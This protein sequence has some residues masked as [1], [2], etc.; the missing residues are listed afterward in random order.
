M[1]VD[2]TGVAVALA[3]IAGT[4]G[5]AALTQHAATRNRRLDAMIHRDARAEE[6][7]E[8]ARETANAEKRA[9]YV[10]LNAA[11]RD[12]RAAGHDL[13]VDKHPG[14]DLGDL[15]PL[16]IARTKYRDVYARA[17]MVLPRR[18]LDVATEVNRCLG[19][20]YRALLDLD[21]GLSR[22]ISVEDLHEWYDRTLSDAVGLLRQVLR[23]DLGVEEY[24]NSIGSELE[25]L[26]QARIKLWATKD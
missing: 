6:R 15:E 16:E 10:E 19:R 7:Q 8:A 12:F 24:S 5:A 25:R 14:A 22:S 1:S 3:G 11:A 26:R 20:S 13:I 18:E 23:E 17:Q 9:I 4:L 21:R 2:V